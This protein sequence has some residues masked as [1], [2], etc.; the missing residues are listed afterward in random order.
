MATVDLM[1]T[2]QVSDG[3]SAADT[4]KQFQQSRP[5]VAGVRRLLSNTPLDGV[6]KYHCTGR[7]ADAA[8]L[9]VSSYSAPGVC[10][11]NYFNTVTSGNTLGTV[12][13]G[14]ALGYY[15]FAH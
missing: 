9:L 3:L 11:V 1:T 7:S 8:V 5:S 6:T 13:K 12:R 15:S 4:L 14:C 2:L 10:G